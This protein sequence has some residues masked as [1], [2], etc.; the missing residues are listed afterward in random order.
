M[1]VRDEK[2]E[3]FDKVKRMHI[4]SVDSEVSL[5]FVCLRGDENL[6]LSHWDMIKSIYDRYIT[7]KVS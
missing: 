2:E 6:Q 3:L 1:R 4:T 7:G 5:V